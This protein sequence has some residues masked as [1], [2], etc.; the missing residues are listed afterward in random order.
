MGVGCQRQEQTAGSTF[1]VVV[2]ET[3]AGTIKAELWPDKAPITVGNFLRYVDEKFYDDTIF[4][5][6]LPAFMIQGGGFTIQA[7]ATGTE[8]VKKRTREPIRNEAN[9]GL[10]NV[11]GTLAMARTGDVN[12]A[13]AQFF[14][15]TVDNRVLDHGVRDYG[16]AVFGQVI[17]GMDVV[18][19]IE[20]GPL[21]GDPQQG[22][23]RNPVVIKSVRRAGG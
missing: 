10:R 21:I 22:R 5:R 23:P 1:P 14:I 17:S 6:C 4:H 9:N 20:R 15:N 13:T 11:R 7:T 12:S 18:G 3:S 2:I 19:E 8:Q 16:Y